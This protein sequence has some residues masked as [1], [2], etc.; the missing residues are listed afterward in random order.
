MPSCALNY[1]DTQH[2]FL[3]E[4]NYSDTQHNNNK[5]IQLYIHVYIISS[6]LLPTGCFGEG[7]FDEFRLSLFELFVIKDAEIQKL[8]FGILR[9]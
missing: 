1:S 9:N 8:K 2:F 4:H 6:S 5:Y 3:T 7:V